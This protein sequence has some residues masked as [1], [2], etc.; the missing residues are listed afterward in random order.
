MYNRPRLLETSPT[1][2]SAPNS[3]PDLSATLRVKNELHIK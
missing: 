1:N 3:P 2:H